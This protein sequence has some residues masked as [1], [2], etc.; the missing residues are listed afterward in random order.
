MDTAEKQGA[1]IKFCVKNGKTGAETLQML[2]SA[3]SDD[4]LR[5]AV[6]YQWVKRFKEGRESLKDDPRPGRPSTAR[7]EQNVAQ[8]REKIRADLCHDC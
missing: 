7:N 4:C 8:V 5:Q 6:V 3:F 2:R 1:C